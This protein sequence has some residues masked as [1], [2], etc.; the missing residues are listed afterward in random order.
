LVQKIRSAAVTDSLE[1][2]KAAQE[3]ASKVLALGRSIRPGSEDA[4]LEQAQ[5]AVDRS[6]RRAVRLALSR[7]ALGQKVTMTDQ[8]KQV[9]TRVKATG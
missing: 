7:Q 6:M 4:A 2:E 9:A 8:Q 1:W 5:G 3:A